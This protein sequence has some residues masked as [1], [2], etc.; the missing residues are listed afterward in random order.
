MCERMLNMHSFLIITWHN[1][2]ELHPQTE[3]T[4]NSH[5]TVRLCGVADDA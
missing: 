2:R 4:K 5:D 1:R 3:R